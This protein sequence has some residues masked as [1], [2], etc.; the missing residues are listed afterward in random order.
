MCLGS[1]VHTSQDDAV[2]LLRVLGFLED[3]RDEQTTACAVL[4]CAVLC[5]ATMAGMPGQGLSKAVH[6][7]RIFEISKE[8]VK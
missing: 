7:S 2:R 3:V 8:G 4:C 1:P 5:C 6:T